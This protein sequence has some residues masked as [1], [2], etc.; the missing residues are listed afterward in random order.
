MRVKIAEVLQFHI[1]KTCFFIREHS[2]RNPPRNSFRLFREK[3]NLHF[4]TCCI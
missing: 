4:K 1:L 3:G 2:L